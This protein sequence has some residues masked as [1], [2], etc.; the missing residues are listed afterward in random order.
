LVTIVR[1]SIHLINDLP[2][3]YEMLSFVRGPTGK[4]EAAP[5]KFDDLIMALAIAHQARGQQSMQLAPKEN[6]YEPEYESS[7]GRTGW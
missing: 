5:G 6:Y 7:F 2:T 3:L 1:E 4:P